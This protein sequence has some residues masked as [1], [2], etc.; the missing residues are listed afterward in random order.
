MLTAVYEYI[1]MN[2]FLYQTEGLYMPNPEQHFFFYFVVAL[3]L[4]LVTSY[5]AVRKGRSQLGWFILGFLFGIIPLIVLY[6]LP[7]IPNGIPT[8]SVSEPDPSLIPTPIKP[9]ELLPDETKLWYYLDQDHKQTGP[10]SIVALRDLWDRGLLGLE[11]YIWS[12]GMPQWKRLE[13]MPD[14]KDAIN[15]EEK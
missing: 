7:D 12:E 13:D 15:K 4:G 6:F 5:F 10:V 1:T 3:V 8:M 14:L 9:P 11:T 2:F